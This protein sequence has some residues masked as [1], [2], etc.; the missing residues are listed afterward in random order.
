MTFF[1]NAVVLTMDPRRPEARV[2]GVSDGRIVRLDDQ[3]PPEPAAGPAVDLSGRAILPL[4]V[5]S[6]LHFTSYALFISRLFVYDARD[7]SSLLDMIGAHASFGRGPIL[8]FGASAWALTE[9]RLPT[10]AELDQAA[11]GRPLFLVKYDGH[12]A[13]L[14][15]AMLAALPPRVAAERGY[16]AETGVLEAEAFYLAARTIT[17]K[18]SKMDITRSVIRTAHDMAR[19]GY[20]LIHAVEGVGFKKDLDV[21]GLM[22]LAK[23][24]PLQTRVFFQTLDVD[25]VIKLKLPRVGGC[26]ACALDGAPGT[27]DIALHEPF[28]DD[29]D[30]RGILFYDQAVVDEFVDHAHQAGLQI[31]MHAIGDRAVTQAVDAFEKALRKNPRK[32]HRH[33]IIHA[34]LITE[35]DKDRIA[36]LGLGVATQPSMLTLRQEPPEYI[37]KILGDRVEKM[38]PIK[39]LVDRGVRVSFGSDAPVTLPDLTT[40]IHAAVNHPNPDEAVDVTTALALHTRTGF[41]TSFDEDA[42]G[43][44]AEGLPADFMVLNQDPRQMTDLSGLKV[45]QVYR[46]GKPLP[47]QAGGMASLMGNMLRGYLTGRKI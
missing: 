44:L 17:E 3:V 11:A 29:P 5:D 21:T 4:A 38:I 8:G 7:L 43:R 42:G 12:S 6:H 2:L 46:A 9:R 37:E 25:R 28:A 41:E 14:N 35:R 1:Q 22:K 34:Y 47:E 24:L 32:D 18:V 19:K 40:S 10:L 27:H 23:G 20:G 26:F 36:S 39:S 45:E 33:T 16:D 13:L 15:S 30:D 31:E